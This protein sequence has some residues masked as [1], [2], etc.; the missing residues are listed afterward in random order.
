MNIDLEVK[1][2]WE[3]GRADPSDTQGDDRERLAER[4]G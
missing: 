3:G 2:L 4:S 1:V